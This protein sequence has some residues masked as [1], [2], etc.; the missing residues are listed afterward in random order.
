MDSVTGLEVR[1]QSGVGSKARRLVRVACILAVGLMPSVSR[2]QSAAVQQLLQDADNAYEREDYRKAVANYERAIL[3]EP[4]G[5]QPGVYAKRASIFLFEKKYQEGLN[6]IS[7]VAEQVYPDDPLIL[8]QKAVIMSKLPGRKKDAVDLAEKVVGHRPSS[9]AL[10]VMVGDFY[11]NAG[12]GAADKTV[13]AYEAYLKHR[14]DGLA[15]ADKLIRVKLGLMYLH[16]AD[17]KNAETQFD[18]SLR[19]AGDPQLDPNAYKG[20]CAAY[21]GQENWDK[22]LTMCERVIKAREAIKNDPSIYYN[23]GRA[24]LRRKRYDDAVNAANS[25]IGARAREPKGYLLRGQVYFEQ[26]K[27]NQAEMEFNR[28]DQ[29]APRNPEV[30]RWLGRTYLSQKPPQPRKAVERLTAALSASPDDVETIGNLSMAYLA[31]GKPQN[32][33]HAIEKGLALPGQDKNAWLLVTAG[34]A[35]YEGGDFSSSFRSYARALSLVKTDSA[36]RIGAV[37]ALNRKAGEAFKKGDYAAAQKDL[38]EALTLDEQSISTN[39]NLGLLYVVKAN[40]KEAIER[41]AVRLKRTP[42]D[43]LTNRLIAKAYLGVGNKQK[44]SE[45]Y[46]KASEE[47]QRLR[48][49]PLVG[50][51]YTEWAPLLLD[52]GKLDDAVDKLEQAAQYGVNQPFVQAARRNL[53]VAYFHRGYSRL[54]TR[55]AAGAVADLEGA[56]REPALLKGSEEDVFTFAL[57]LAYLA[58]N[59]E[60]RAA[61]VLASFAQKIKGDGVNWLKP[62]YD[63]VGIELFGAY[64]QYR[65]GTLA[66]RMKAAPVFEKLTQKT[67]GKLNAKLKDLLRSSLEF[68]AYDQ[69]LKGSSREADA[70][71]KKAEGQVQGDRRVIDHNLAVLGMD[72]GGKGDALRSIFERLGDRVPEALVNLGILFDREGEAKKAYE[73]WSAARARGARAAKL[74]EWIE[75]KKRIFNF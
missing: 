43:L 32:A 51:V 20:L 6:W 54:K 27:W 33:I 9:F 60:A 69:F 11:Y 12:A 18:A 5:V 52:A 25:Y 7:S 57:G 65:E 68:M 48:N 22:A 2:G 59:Q 67:T 26:G 21:A 24:Y 61:Q 35:Y 30:A 62:P 66:A 39:F 73:L 1:A 29:L 63:K 74:D 44:A 42:N 46:E 17:Y 41:L 13:A 34:D 58:N 55:Q 10:Q 16:K 49:M 36:A 45:H 14:P 8:E 75:A 4:K 28:A 31:D 15:R 53:Q 72:R 37:N 50:E 56:T 19:I 64:A 71:L 47:A 70:L 38:L 40:H 23:V 3:A